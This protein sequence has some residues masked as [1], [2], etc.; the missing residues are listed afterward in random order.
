VPDK[1]DHEK[2]RDLNFTPDIFVR[3]SN[4]SWNKWNVSAS[5]LEDSQGPHHP[6]VG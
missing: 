3:F 5:Y 2:R 1:T 6:A 4:V